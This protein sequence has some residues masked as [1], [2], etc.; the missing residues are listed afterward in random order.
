MIINYEIAKLN[1]CI[2]TDFDMLQS[3]FSPL[4]A[5]SFDKSDVNVNISLGDIETDNN[6]VYSDSTVEVYRNIDNSYKKVYYIKGFN[7]KKS[8]H[9]S[10]CG[11][12][13]VLS[14]ECK[15][16]G[17][18]MYHFWGMI[19]LPHILIQNQRLM[20]HC[21]YIIS[22]GK[23]VLF[24]GKSGTGK[25]TQA[26]I[27][28]KFGGAKIVNGDKAVIYAENGKLYA[29][30]LPIAGTSNICLNETA[31]IKAIVVLMQG[32]ENSVEVLS[33]SDKVSL[34]ASNV[35]FD[36]WRD[37]E[38]LDVIDLCAKMTQL[39]NVIQ[40]KCLPDRSAF[41]YLNKVIE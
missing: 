2:I 26:D 22:N 39:T 15:A 20:L 28:E 14:R 6:T 30:S 3:G 23:A 19:D 40:Y 17:R 38:S 25:S 9:F 29:A 33:A 8:N 36:V 11:S 4:F 7:N 24:C 41:E 21:S 18:D 10:V 12:N 34:V 27:W 31:E 35:I 5:T 37:G 1:I 13:C 32:K 16:S